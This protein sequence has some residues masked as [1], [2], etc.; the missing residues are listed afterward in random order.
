MLSVIG[1][2]SAI[3]LGATPARGTDLRPMVATPLTGNL[4][5]HQDIPLLCPNLDFDTPVTH[6][7]G[8]IEIVPADGIDVIGGKMF[9]LTGV[10]VFFDGFSTHVECAGNT[11]DENYSEVGAQL[12]RAVAFTGTPAGPGVYNFTIPKEAFVVHEAAIR[13][14]NNGPTGPDD[15]LKHPGTDVTGTID[16]NLRT[17]HLHLEIDTTLNVHF[18][19]ADHFESGSQTADIDGTLAY[20]DTDGDTIPD[21]DDNC[22]FTPNADQHIVTTPILTPPPPVK[23][24][25]CLDRSFGVA[26]ATDICF[27]R[28]V[29]VTNNAPDPFVRGANPFNWSANDGVDP[30]QLASQTVTIDDKTPPIILTTPADFTINDCRAVSDSELGSPTGSD[31]CGGAVTFTNNKPP[32]FFAG[33]TNVTWTA[34]DLSGNTSTSTQT[35]TVVDTTPPAAS[36]VAVSPTGNAFQVSASDHC[37]TPVIRLGTYQLAQGE[38]IQIQETGQNGVTLVNNI[39]SDNVRHFQVGKGQAVITATDAAHNVTTVVCIK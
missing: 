2:V 9:V 8:R 33:P 14:Q 20:P 29:T 22:P 23:L 1:A 38:V 30:I 3:A 19:G 18:L 39:S 26:T 16:L 10:S 5:I 28:P 31:D 35:V 7:L 21:K 17:V 6:G 15:S 24:L 11:D 12:G 13:S 4:H 36:C 37:D 25:S 34:H 27:G 32:I